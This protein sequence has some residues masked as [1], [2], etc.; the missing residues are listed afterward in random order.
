MNVS[1]RRVRNALNE[2]ESLEKLKVFIQK[3]HIS[4]LYKKL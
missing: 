2:I 1:Q 3:N 4:M